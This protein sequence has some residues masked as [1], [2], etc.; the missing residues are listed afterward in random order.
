MYILIIIIIIIVVDSGPGSSL[1]FW[2]EYMHSMH[3][4]V[5][6]KISKNRLSNLEIII[7]EFDRSIKEMPDHS[8]ITSLM[9]V[10]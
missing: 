7:M 6:C 1:P 2:T 9:I 8:E 3:N 4:N 5:L 10:S